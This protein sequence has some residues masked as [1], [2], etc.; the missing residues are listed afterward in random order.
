MCL[1]AIISVSVPELVLN[2][3]LHRSPNFL[4]LGL[5]FLLKFYLKGK[6]TKRCN[7]SS[8]LINHAKENV[9]DLSSQV[10]GLYKIYS[11]H[12]EI[13]TRFLFGTSLQVKSTQ[14]FPLP[15]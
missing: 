11:K 7:L 14:E 5:Y 6:Q 9:C 13:M 3:I 2:D 15:L 12:K 10:N 4:G 8:Q 1:Q